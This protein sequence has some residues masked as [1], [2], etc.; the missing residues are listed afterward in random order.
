MERRLCSSD[1]GRGHWSSLCSSWN[2]LQQLGRLLLKKKYEK[3][4][5]ARKNYFMSAVFSL[6][7]SSSS[8]QTWIYPFLPASSGWRYSRCH[9]GCGASHTSGLCKFILLW[10]PLFL[11]NMQLIL[12]LEFKNSAA[13]TTELIK[14][15]PFI[16]ADCTLSKLEESYSRQGLGLGILKEILGVTKVSISLEP[17]EL[18]QICLHI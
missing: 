1:C 12:S 8:S 10:K 2:F 17:K 3:M 16:S 11:L 18:D 14:F 6:F 15:P 7:T 4:T 13:T 9:G 5:S